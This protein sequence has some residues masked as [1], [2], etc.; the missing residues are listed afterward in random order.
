MSPVVPIPGLCVGV[1]NKMLLISSQ[2]FQEAL[3]NKRESQNSQAQ[4][5]A[6]T[7]NHLEGFLKKILTC[8][9]LNSAYN[10]FPTRDGE[11]TTS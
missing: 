4:L 5:T 9:N 3:K 8:E 1:D 11:I 10:V 2:A 7:R 6:W